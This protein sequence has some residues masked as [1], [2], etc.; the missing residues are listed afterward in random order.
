MN[1]QAWIKRI[2]KNYDKIFV[3]FSGGKDSVASL[4]FALE[5]FD[6]NKIE[7]LWVDVDYDFPELYPYII[8]VLHKANIKLHILKIPT[9]LE[10]LAQAFGNLSH[11]TRWC[12]PE[13]KFISISYFF[14]NL[15]QNKQYIS[16]EGTRWA[17]S[18]AREGRAY[19]SDETES[20]VSNPTF[21]P[22]L[23]FSDRHVCNYCMQQGYPLHPTYNFFDRSGCYICP[24]NTIYGWGILRAVY[25]N[26]FKK[27]IQFLKYAARNV[28][29]KRFYAKDDI[30]RI[31]KQ[32]VIK[33]TFVPPYTAGYVMPGAIE[34]ETRI[35]FE[36]IRDDPS[37]TFER[38][39][40]DSNISIDHKIIETP[41]PERHKTLL[42]NLNKTDDNTLN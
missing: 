3:S 32:T 14:D 41:Q 5:N 37:Y 40:E 1:K 20:F 35:K 8:Y 12:G 18:R 36:D 4:L 10:Q 9:P 17:E 27:H 19:F 30:K 2:Q 16:F 21:R 42:A 28:N 34:K 33:E 13:G 26:L 15:P 24:E 25:P 22:V 38:A 29:W 11:R 39:V 7:A 23:D 6:R 31:T